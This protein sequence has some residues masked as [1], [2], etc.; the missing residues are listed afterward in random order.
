MPD[1]ARLREFARLAIRKGTLPR[2]EP[3]RVWG[4]SGVGALCSVCETAV[5][6]NQLEYELEF[7]RGRDSSRTLQFHLRCFAA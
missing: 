2:G 7:A 3:A 4:G 5:T 1:E 6:Q